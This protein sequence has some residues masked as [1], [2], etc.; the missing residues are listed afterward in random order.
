MTLSE[1]KRAQIP[2]D[3]APVLMPQEQ[4]ID[5]TTGNS[6]VKRGLV[7][8]RRPATILVTA[9]RVIIFSEKLGGYDAQDYAY[10][11]LTGV[12]HKTG[13]TGGLINLRAAGDSADVQQVHRDDVERISQLIRERMVLSHEPVR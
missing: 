8:T 10:G 6:R 13:V 5:A 7:T 9:L 1:K 12:D 3:A 11:L 4:V 2:Q